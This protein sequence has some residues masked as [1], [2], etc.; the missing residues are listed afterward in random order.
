MADDVVSTGGA[1]QIAQEATLQQLLSAVAGS[2]GS[3][4]AMQVEKLAKA[5][6]VAADEEKRLAETVV[7]VTE[8]SQGLLKSFINGTAT[9]SGVF[10]AMGTLPG[11]IGL[12]F[13]GLSMIAGFQEEAMVSYQHQ[14]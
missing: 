7:K 8:A 5:S 1:G 12:V 11:P 9:T 2:S 3:S 4:A 14:Q 10:G 6:G 13:K